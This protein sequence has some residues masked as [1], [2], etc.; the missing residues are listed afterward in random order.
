VLLA[1][2]YCWSARHSLRQ[3]VRHAV[4]GTPDTDDSHEPAPYRATLVLF[5]ASVVVICLW[6]HAFGAAVWWTLLLL[7]LY[8]VSTVVLTRIVAESGV[9]AVWTPIAAQSIIVSAC[10]SRTVGVRGITALSYLGW[11]IGDTAS[12]SMANIL[13]GYHIADLA[14]LRTRANFG[15]IVVAL[16][17]ALFASHGPSL[18]AI[19]SRSVPGLGWWPRG[20]GASLPQGI[21]ALIQAP[22]PYTLGN[23]GNM[24]LGAG[25]TLGLHLL[26]QR[27]LWWPFHPMG[28][29]ANLGPQ[30]MGDR[31]GFSILVGWLVR[32]LV[33]RF[34]GYRA[35]SQW[36]RAAI[37]ITVG[38][39]VILLLW[40]IVHYFRPIAGVLIIE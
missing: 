14:R 40:T 32:K 20:A 17:A 19:Y 29:A 31:Y 15:L 34:G 10:G 9:F 22:R 2:I 26:R 1:V 6:G 37:G 13:Q 39:A 30:F 5:V 35:Y 24:A 8:L 25:V 12:C 21:A 33:H 4:R 16:M 7:V 3:I 28:Y 38:N 11:K 18:Y 23:Y 36:R 27:F